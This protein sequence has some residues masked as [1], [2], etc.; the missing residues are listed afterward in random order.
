MDFDAGYKFA[1]MGMLK[2]PL[3]RFNISNLGNAGYRNPNS[4]SV[5]NAVAIGTRAAQS[6]SYYLGAPRLASITFSADFQ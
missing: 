3:V 4:G 6:V 5:T 2:S 1:D